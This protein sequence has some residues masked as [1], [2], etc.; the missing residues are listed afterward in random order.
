MSTPTSA[1]PVMA[2]DETEALHGLEARQPLRMGDQVHVWDP[3]PRGGVDQTPRCS[4]AVLLREPQDGFALVGRLGA[5]WR[6]VLRHDARPRVAELTGL[7]L[8]G[9]TPFQSWHRTEEC[10]E[11]R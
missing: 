7:Y 10:P 9:K 2:S 4:L 8:D 5:A 11:A 3:F 1:P 6:Q